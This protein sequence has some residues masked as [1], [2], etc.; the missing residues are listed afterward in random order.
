MEEAVDL[1]LFDSIATVFNLCDDETE[2]FSWIRSGLSQSYLAELER[3]IAHSYL[4]MTTLLGELHCVLHQVEKCFRIDLPVRKNVIWNLVGHDQLDSQLLF[5][6]LYYV[7]LHEVS[8]KVF[9]VARQV[10][11]T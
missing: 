1:I 11:H 9:N 3:V 2:F 6:R 8:E 4:D 10:V 5:D 7:G